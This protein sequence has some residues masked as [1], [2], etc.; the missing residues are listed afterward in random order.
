MTLSSARSPLI[1]RI[2]QGETA[3]QY[4]I[5]GAGPIDAVVC[6]AVWAG[7]AGNRMRPGDSLCHVD[8]LYY[9]FGINTASPGTSGA[10]GRPN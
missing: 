1:R 3:G 2:E 10:S 8:L 9:S 7:D 4:E 6:G 5:D